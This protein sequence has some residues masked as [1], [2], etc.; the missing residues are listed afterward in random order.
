MMYDNLDT[1]FS[2]LNNILQK[3]CNL[4]IAKPRR[5][6]TLAASMSIDWQNELPKK[7]INYANEKISSTLMDE[8]FDLIKFEQMFSNQDAIKCGKMIG[9][10]V[11][12]SRLKNGEFIG[13]LYM[14][15][16]A[17]RTIYQINGLV[18][19][20]DKQNITFQNVQN[21]ISLMSVAFGSG[22]Q[23]TTVDQTFWETRLYESKTEI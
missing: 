18:W 14:V 8:I 23:V 9:P 7:H 22:L 12:I 21:Y 4:H 20:W 6:T 5:L 3:E 10:V 17:N 1:Q 11:E 2:N 13:V 15:S 19:I 16:R